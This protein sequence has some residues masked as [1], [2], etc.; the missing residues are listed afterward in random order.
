MPTCTCPRYSY[1]GFQN[2]EAANSSELSAGPDGGMGPLSLSI[3]IYIYMCVGV[4][5]DR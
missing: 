5:V 2:T 4:W 3:Y 1:Q